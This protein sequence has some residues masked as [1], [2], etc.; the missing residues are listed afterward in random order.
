MLYVI[1]RDHLA[2]FLSKKLFTDLEIGLTEVFLAR[3]DRSCIEAHPI[4]L[5]HSR[6][7]AL[8]KLVED[9]TRL[10]HG[11]HTILVGVQIKDTP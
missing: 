11:D 6:P 3:L 7:R 1:D 8:S 10:L 4:F 2:M 5:L 9:S